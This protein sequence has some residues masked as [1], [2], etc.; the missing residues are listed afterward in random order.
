MLMGSGPPPPVRPLW[1]SIRKHSLLVVVVVVV[2]V[3]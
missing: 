2:V 3:V 1:A